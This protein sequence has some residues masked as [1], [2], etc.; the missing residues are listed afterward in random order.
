[1][2][3]QVQVDVSNILDAPDIKHLKTS[4]MEYANIITGSPLF[5][6]NNNVPE[7]TNLLYTFLEDLYITEPEEV[8]N[9][10]NQKPSKKLIENLFKQFGIS[11]KLSR[12]FPDLLKTKTAYMLSKLF[13]AK[14]SN[15]TFEFFNEIIS[16]FYHHLNFYNVRVQQRQFISKYE[17]PIVEKIYHLNPNLTIH[18]KYSMLE[19]DAS[20]FKDDDIG[21]K[22]FTT[23]HERYHNVDFIIKL[24]EPCTEAVKIKLNYS[25]EII[26]PKGESQITKTFKKYDI[27]DK[28]VRDEDQLIYELEPVLINDP[29]SVITQIYENDLRTNKYLMQKEDFFN[30]NYRNTSPMNVFPIITNV[31]YIQFGT[32]ETMDAMEFL[33][34]L[35]RMFA[36]T[37]TQDDL[38][39]FSIDGTVI[40]LPMSEYTSL[41]TYIKLREIQFN[42][43]GWEWGE[44]KEI[45][46]LDFANMVYPKEK[47]TEI[48]DL[49]VY[50]KDMRHNHEIFL[51]FKRRYFLLIQEY[52]QRKSTKIFKMTEFNEFLAGQIPN[53]FPT[54]WLRLEEFYPNGENIIL[55]KD[56]N[57]LMKQQVHFLYDTYLP[58]NPRELFNIISIQDTEFIGLNNSIYDML[59]LQFIDKY[60]RV[61]QKIDAIDSSIGFLE[62]FLYNYKRV[63]VEVVKSDNLITYFVNDMFKRF[64]L[65]GTFKDEFFDPVID[66]FQQYFFKA[67]LS[68]QNSDTIFH[69]TRDKLQQVTCGTSEAYMVKLNGYFSEFNLTDLTKLHHTQPIFDS[70]SFQESNQPTSLWGVEIINDVTGSHIFSE[71]DDSEYR[72][73]NKI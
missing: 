28:G 41:L 68:Y 59:K 32:S 62:L 40:K 43:P 34:D 8:I 70:T 29:L 72:D 36:M 61:I 67:E 51:E 57:L 22:V 66:L 60:P 19:Q 63:L 10:V 33:P 55:S 11:D 9:F 54:F 71:A 30:T 42:N 20:E 73:G 1:M 7:I 56:Q 21:V 48:Y 24:F 58:D 39:S 3:Q 27:Y 38:F 2:S 4:L 16:E 25:D 6:Q 64:L 15:R 49:I 5:N 17:T 45:Q 35:V 47:L 12:N 14:G 13:E 31:L 53:D 23:I 44:N 37:S 50:Y 46:S 69:V 65:A 26:I 18:S 52:Q